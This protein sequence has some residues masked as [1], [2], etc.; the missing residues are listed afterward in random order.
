MDNPSE[1]AT[2]TTSFFV[3]LLRK[4]LLLTA[5]LKVEQQG[6]AYVDNRRFLLCSTEQSLV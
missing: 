1:E 6:M 2:I 3:S 5:T 4:G